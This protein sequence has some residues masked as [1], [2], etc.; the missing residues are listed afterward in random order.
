MRIQKHEMSLSDQVGMARPHNCNR[1]RCLMSHD[2]FRHFWASYKLSFEYRI[3]SSIIGPK[4]MN[5]TF[6]VHEFMNYEL[7]NGVRVTYNESSQFRMH[8][9]GDAHCSLSW[10]VSPT[11]RT[12]FLLRPI[13]LVCSIPP[14]VS[15]SVTGETMTGPSRDWWKCS[16]PRRRRPYRS[17][18]ARSLL[19]WHP[20][21]TDAVNGRATYHE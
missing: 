17:G 2:K 6:T 1:S 13:P 15:G 11:D 7:L 4:T 18:V 20:T 14:P 21:I 5:G 19:H 9:S 8:H 3:T 16:I 10:I 12:L